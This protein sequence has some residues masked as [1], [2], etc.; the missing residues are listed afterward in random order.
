MLLLPLYVAVVVVA[1]VSNIDFELY[2]YMYL[3]VCKLWFESKK[4][5]RGGLRI[6][7]F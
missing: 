2:V 6:L 4:R 7:F 5:G 3:N 1:A